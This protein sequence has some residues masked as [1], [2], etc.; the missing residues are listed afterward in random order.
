MAKLNR[1]QDLQECSLGHIIISVIM[2][3]FSDTRKQVTFGAKLQHDKDGIASVHDLKEGNHIGMMAGFVVQLNL[4]LLEPALPMVQT[5][6][7]QGLDGVGH[8]GRLVD[9]GVHHA[10]RSYP[11]DSR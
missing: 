1:V 7:V 6:L 2:A 3:T 5:D 4:P 10:I 11:D 8:V 9:G